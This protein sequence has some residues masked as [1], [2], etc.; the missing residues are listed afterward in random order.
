MDAVPFLFEDAEFRDE[1]PS[2]LEVS[3]D[4]YEYLQ[5]TYTNDVKETFDMIYQWR[6]FL[7]D[8]VR[9]HGGDA[10]VM[11]T[12]AYTDMKNSMK[13]Y[14]NNTHDGAHFTFNFEMI[15]KLNSTS[16]ANTI[17]ATVTNWLNHL[18]DRYVSNWVVSMKCLKSIANN[19]RRLFS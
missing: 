6:A 13:Y 18:P 4:E 16:D 14:G 11:M 17:V 1:L 9:E 8:Y 19:K 3:E 7:D 12:E 5:H 10:R 15:T 2:G